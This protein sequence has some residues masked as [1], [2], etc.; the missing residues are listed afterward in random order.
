MK[1]H[2]KI[3]HI[4]TGEWCTGNWRLYT[5]EPYDTISSVAVCRGHITNCIDMAKQYEHAEYNYADFEIIEYRLVRTENVTSYF[6]NMNKTTLK[7]KLSKIDPQDIVKMKQN[8]VFDS[9]E[10]V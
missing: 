4:P 1:G 10:T 6:K 7:K 5:L 3:R 9:N 2:F 8:G